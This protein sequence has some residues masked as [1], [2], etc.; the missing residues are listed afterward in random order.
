MVLNIFYWQAD[1]V[2]SETDCFKRINGDFLDVPTHTLQGSQN[3]LKGTSSPRI[4]LNKCI[5]S[6]N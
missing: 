1:M 5:H 4:I 6:D 2:N 3:V